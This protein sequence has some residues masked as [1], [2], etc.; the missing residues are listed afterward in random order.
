MKY[1]YAENYKWVMKELNGTQTNGTISCVHGLEEVMLLK[2]PYT[3]SDLQFQCFSY[4][5]TNGIVHSR[6]NTIKFVWNHSRLPMVKAISSKKKG[7]GDIVLSNVKIYY[8]ARVHFSL[9]WERDYLLPDF[10]KRKAK[11]PPRVMTRAP[12]LDPVPLKEQR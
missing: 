11:L 9:R 2:C 12:K 5:S 8:K 4:Q 6:K 10:I 3:H 1:L 7:P